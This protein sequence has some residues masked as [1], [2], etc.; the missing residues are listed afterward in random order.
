M[1]LVASYLKIIIINIGDSN[2]PVLSYSPCSIRNDFFIHGR[3]LF[4]VDIKIPKYV[5]MFFVFR[6]LMR[7]ACQPSTAIAPG[8]L[9]SSFSKSVRSYVNVFILLPERSPAR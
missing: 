8:A 3:F 2:W 6:K 1:I 7:A 5:H 4:Q 9:S